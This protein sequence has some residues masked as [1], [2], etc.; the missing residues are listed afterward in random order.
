MILRRIFEKCAVFDCTP[1]NNTTDSPRKVL[2][3][4][5]KKT[6]CKLAFFTQ[7]DAE[8][9]RLIPHNCLGQRLNSGASSFHE[10][11]FMFAILSHLLWGTAVNCN[12]HS[13]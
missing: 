13:G 5:E 11:T 1:R 2:L 10:Q 7:Y 6:L 3:C 9:R 8:I 12:R 4:H